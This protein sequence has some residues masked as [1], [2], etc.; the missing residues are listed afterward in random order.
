MDPK[1][2]VSAYSVRQSNGHASWVAHR[3][4]KAL[5]R[6]VGH[7]FRDGR[8]QGR[9]DDFHAYLEF[10]PACLGRRYN[11]QASHY[12][13][14][15]IS[16]DIP[17]DNKTTDG[18]FATSI[19]RGFDSDDYD[20]TFDHQYLP[21]AQT[22]VFADYVLG[23]NAQGTDFIDKARPERPIASFGQ[24][25]IELRDLPQLPLFLK[26][27]AK[28]FS[29]LGGEYLNVE[30]G[31]KPFLK[32]LRSAYAFQQRFKKRYEFLVRNNGVP[33]RRR[34]KKVVTIND[35]VVL[36]EGSLTK[37]WGHLGNE[38]IGGN[39]LLSGYVVGGPMGS[40]YDYSGA[41]YQGQC[42]YQ[43]RTILTTTV[44]NCGTFEY[45][46]PDIGSDH[47]TD[48]AKSIMSGLE[49]TPGVL[50]DVIPWSW[51]VN[52]FSNV[53]QIVHNLTDAKLAN[54][55]LTNCYSMYTE[56]LVH[57][58]E[59]ST[60]WEGIAS[61]IVDTPSRLVIPAG[62]DSLVYSRAEINKLRHQ[63]SPF[64]F[65]VPREAFSASQ[66]AILA[67]L[68]IAQGDPY[69]KTRKQLAKGIRLA[70]RGVRRII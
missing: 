62:S 51:L 50:Y 18:I 44:W 34:T 7:L 22:P 59:I 29:D 3:E 30:F 54:E 37:P 45:Y 70:K 10:E 2:D 25:L 13:M 53:G 19:A 68:G 1:L 55:A 48:K 60:H 4:H 8:W 5:L 67:A 20:G 15:G 21:P 65:G 6:S 58:V 23:L 38:D 32:D 63:A 26:Q 69:F 14:T 33:I 39:L 49:V 17:T 36:C 46:V 9:E 57:E 56:K 11:F 12:E 41:L 66:W 52:W 27:R 42:D 47:W 24:F 35:P 43:Y 16:I 31:W 28:R 61:G 40:L 64:G